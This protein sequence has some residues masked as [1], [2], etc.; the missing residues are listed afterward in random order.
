[1]QDEEL[2]TLP[3]C[4]EVQIYRRQN[5]EG[6][7]NYLVKSQVTLGY[8][9]LNIVSLPT[10]YTIERKRCGMIKNETTSILSDKVSKVNIYKSKYGL[11]RTASCKGH[12]N[13]E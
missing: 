12:Q 1:M 13:D 5:S 9:F 3:G 11:Q 2:S 10:M 4:K 6:F 8:T 7:A